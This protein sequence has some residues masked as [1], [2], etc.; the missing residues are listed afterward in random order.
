MK[1]LK[2]ILLILAS[3]LAIPCSMLT[4]FGAVWFTLPNITTTEFGIW[5]LTKVSSTG[6][7]WITIISAILFVVLSILRLIFGRH[8]SS[9]LKNFFIHIVTWSMCAIG[10]VLAV[11][12]FIY[13]NPLVAEKVVITIPRKISIG[14]TLI[15][16]IFFH[17]FSG[18]LATIINRK[19]QAYDNAKEA[20]QVG[21]SSVIWVNFLKL[22]EIFFPE[23]LVLLLICYCVSWNVASYF[24]IVLIA[25]IIPVFGNIIS[26]FNTRHEITV[27][28]EKER[29]ELAKRVADNMKR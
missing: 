15:V 17:I 20:N 9:K 8:T 19:I 2:S 5:V 29:D 4:T 11:Y 22:F 7:F 16:L 10:V 28:Q 25:S 24:I 13:C 6:I 12:T 14:V 1:L 18:K 27:N 3:I 23:M 26:D 21:R